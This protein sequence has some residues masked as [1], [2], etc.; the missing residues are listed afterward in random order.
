ADLLDAPRPDDY[1][2]D[3]L[4]RAVEMLRPVRERLQEALCLLNRAGA[5][6]LPLRR[7]FDELLESPLWWWRW[8]G[9]ALV[10]QLP[11]QKPTPPQR[12]LMATGSH[13]V[14]PKLLDDLRASAYRGQRMEP[15]GD[16]PSSGVPSDPPKRTGEDR[17]RTRWQDV[18][19]RLKRLHDQGQPW[20]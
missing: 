1:S 7:R 13:P 16:D 18:A 11:G 12:L 15:F 6:A 17:H 19:E 5:S 4:L 20:T 8:T 3:G 2:P 14:D 9:R 10:E